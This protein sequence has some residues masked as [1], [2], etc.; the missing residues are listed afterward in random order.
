VQLFASMDKSCEELPP[1]G[2]RRAWIDGD[3]R[4]DLAWFEDGEGKVKVRT[5]HNRIT[6]DGTPS[7][8][9][10]EETGRQPNCEACGYCLRGKRGDVTFLQ[11]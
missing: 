3:E 5:E 4:A 6:E 1:A 7:Y 10:P 11:H 9:C 8:V 2:W